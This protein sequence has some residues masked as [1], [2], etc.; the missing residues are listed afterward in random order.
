[1]K[2]PKIVVQ[3]CIR[4]SLWNSLPLLPVVQPIEATDESLK[5]DLDELLKGDTPATF[6]SAVTIVVPL[7]TR[8]QTTRIHPSEMEPI[9]LEKMIVMKRTISPVQLALKT[10]ILVGI[11]IQLLQSTW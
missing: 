11:W 2:M 3:K 9:L 7:D 6:P 8:E 1:M 10:L 5:E 4:S